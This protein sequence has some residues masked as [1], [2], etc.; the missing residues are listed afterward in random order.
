MYEIDGTPI[1]EDVLRK[2]AEELN[3]TFERLL[4]INSDLIKRVGETNNPLGSP[5]G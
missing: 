3:I 2:K 4:E 5:T 1:S